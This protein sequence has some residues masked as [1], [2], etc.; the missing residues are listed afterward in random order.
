LVILF[1]NVKSKSNHQLELLHFVGITRIL[2]LF[3][4]GSV[5]GDDDVMDRGGAAWDQS[6]RPAAATEKP[7]SPLPVVLTEE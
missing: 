6:L 7:D 4:W 2:H 3:G 5:P 1:S